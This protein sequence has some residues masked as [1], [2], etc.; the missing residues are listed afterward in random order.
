VVDSP[1]GDAEGARAGWR[2]LA[3]LAV[4]AA[5]ALAGLPAPAAAGLVVLVVAMAVAGSAA[6]GPIALVLLAP[7]LLGEHKTPYFWLEPGLVLLV[8]AGALARWGLGRLALRPPHGLALAAFAAAAIVAVPLDLR[9]LLEDLWLARSLDWPLLLAQGIPD[10]SHLKYL[11]RVLVVLLAAGLYAVAAQPAIGRA[12]VGAAEPLMLLT[13]GLAAFGLARF[14]GLLSTSGEYLTLSFWTWQNPDLR[15]T[16]VAWN[17][18][19]FALFLVLA[20]PLGAALALGDRPARARGLGIA[21]AGL[22]TVA[23]A[24][25]FQRAGYLALAAALAVL[26]GLVA[27]RRAGRAGLVLAAAVAVAAV[28]ALVALDVLVLGG[29]LAG[30]V[31]R[32]ADDPNRLRLWT[33]ALRMAADHPLLGVGTGR[34]AF[35]FREYAGALATGFGPFWGTAHSLYL[36]LLAEQGVIGLASFWILF[37]G[38]WLGAWRRGAALAGPAGVGLAG[39]LA[40]LAGWL[41]YG[42][43]QFTFRVDA[44]VYLAAILAGAAVALAPPAA[45]PGAGASR[46]W[47]AAGLA[48][49]LLLL[50]GRTALA[51]ARPV[52]PGYEAGFHR[53]ERQPDGGAAR[54]TRGR[55]AAS[56]PVQGRV[57]AL[58][59]RAPLPG[60]EARPQAVRVWVDGGAPVVVRLAGPE[61]QTLAVAVERPRGAHVL[62]ELEPAYTVVPAHVA[63]SRDQ[64]RLGVM[65]G[66]LAWRD[67]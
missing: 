35:F 65:V 20:I 54:W 44:L 66:E 51:L 67:P 49:G 18:D 37:G 2:I 11:D 27:R 62:V 61:W 41:L 32:L 28:V 60:V 38:V 12:V 19:Y 21:A 50:G 4:V 43:V 16:A 53:W 48:A 26:G 36:H 39:V 6:G 34:Y 29:R 13:A 63:G 45:A 52:S 15:L 23:L 42:A 57:L 56:V 17:P 40:A 33:T 25:T 1:A 24:L 14:L 58:R 55:A 46:R 47:V 3:S 31:A 9:D 59:F 22:G 5:L 8:L 10:V 30:R 7:L 64:R